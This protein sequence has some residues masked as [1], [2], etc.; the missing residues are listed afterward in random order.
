M[1]V[2]IDTSPLLNQNAGRGIGR[3]T[4]ELLHALRHIA[5][6]DQFRASTDPAPSVIDVIQYPFFDLFFLTLPLRKKAPTVVTIHDVTPLI[7]AKHYPPGI[8]GRIKFFIQKLALRSVS[9]VITDSV[10]SKRDIVEKL[11]VNPEKISVVPLAASSDITRPNQAAID[12]V[13]KKY[14]LPKYYALYVG[15]INYNKNLPFLISSMKNVPKLTLVLV[16]KNMK[17]T[18][19]R[20]G[21]AIQKS[22]ELSG[23][24]KRV[25]LLTEVSSQSSEEL[26]ALYAGATVYVQPS[27]YEGFGLPVLE[28]MQCR[29]PVVCSLGGSLPEVAGDAA[30]YFH[31]HD[32]E[33]CAAA[34]NKVLRFS[35][36]Q[37]LHL[38]SQGVDQAKKYSWLRT[39]QE[40]V[41]VYRKVVVKSPT[42]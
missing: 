22:I 40:T 12:A 14:E 9:H 10:I 31:P 17:N 6:D 41:Q 38:I 3:Y 24:Q 4:Y 13:R 11:G 23:I 39:A 25:R 35:D 33:E 20:E 19:I 2:L 5:P 1:Q 30:L 7:F 42:A 26:S 32:E 15:D 29:T 28:A 27:L 34:I 18:Q 16:G 21:K 36:K 37:R 8:R